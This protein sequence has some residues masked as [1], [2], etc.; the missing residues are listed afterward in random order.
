MAAGK[1]IIRSVLKERLGGGG[2]AEGAA[3]AA[4]TYGPEHTKGVA[5][6]IKNKLKGE[7][8]VVF[9]VLAYRAS[10]K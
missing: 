6:A 2:G 7:A 3:A 9:I 1:E 5:D 10:R 8:A 4:V